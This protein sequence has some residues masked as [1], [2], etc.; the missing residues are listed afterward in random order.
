[1]TG[2]EAAGEMRGFGAMKSTSGKMNTNPVVV[3]GYRDDE[4]LT[5]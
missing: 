5:W 1:M 3:K 4:T 2:K